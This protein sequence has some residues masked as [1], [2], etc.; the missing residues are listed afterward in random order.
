M[1]KDKI[2]GALNEQINAELHSAYIYLSMCA[3][4]ES[5]G[6]SGMAAWMKAQ[7]QEE[8]AHA[9]KLFD[10]VNER[11]G[12]VLLQPIAEVPT[13][14]ASPLAVFE[15]ALAHEEYITGRI[16][17]LVDLAIAERDHATNSFLGWFVDE[18]VE[19]EASAGGIVDQLKLVGDNRGGLFMIDKELGQ[20]V[21][22]ATPQAE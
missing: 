16:N 11:G 9:A 8:M 14:W 17:D 13:S 18:Q 10:F 15:A 3:Y 12:R 22:N 5:Q 6:L 20:R 4:F 2:Q 1:L 7:T 21:F 19:E